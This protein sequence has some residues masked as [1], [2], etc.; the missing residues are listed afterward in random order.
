MELEPAK[1]E[2]AFHAWLSRR[3][4]KARSELAYHRAMDDAATAAQTGESETYLAALRLALQ[5]LPNDPDALYQIGVEEKKLGRLEDSGR[6]FSK[7]SALD[8]RPD[9]LHLVIFSHFQLGQL[10]ELTGEVDAARRSY[11][12]MLEMP[13]RYGSHRMARESMAKLPVRGSD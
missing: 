6:A 11:E 12:R 7:V 13:D 9:Q 4:D 2:P 5:S 10:A 3:A 8:V 1:L